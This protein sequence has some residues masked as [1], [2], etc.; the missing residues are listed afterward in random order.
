M[1]NLNTLSMICNHCMPTCD[2]NWFV[3]SQVIDVQQHLSITMSVNV[4][5]FVTN[6]Q[7]LIL[8]EKDAEIAETKYVALLVLITVVIINGRATI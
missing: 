7:K 1:V 2:S 3:L 8:K 5:N 6:T 4:E